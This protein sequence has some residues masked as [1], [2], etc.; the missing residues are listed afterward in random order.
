MK[1]TLI[2]LATLAAVSGTAFAQSNVTLSGGYGLVVGTSKTG[3]TST[4][5]QIARQT[6]NLNFAGT[7]DLGGG[8]KAGFQLQT[9]IGAHA[10]TSLNT[11]GAAAAATTLGDRGANVT[12][13]GAFGTA[14]VGR[15][16]SAVLGLWGAIGDVSQSPVLSGLSAGNSASTSDAKGGDANS[17]VIYGDAYSNYI[18]YS[19]P[20]FNGFSASVALAGVD[21]TTAS[22]KDTTS[23]TL[24]YA[25]GPLAAAVNL[26]D[27]KQTSGQAAVYDIDPAV[28]KA[29][30]PAVGAYKMTTVLASYD[31]GVVKVGLTS[32]QIKLAS[33]VN[34][35]NAMALTAAAPIGAGIVSL[36]YGKRSASASSAVAFG[37]DVKQTHVGY[38]YNLSKRT[39]LNLISNKINRAGTAADVTETSLVV[40]HTF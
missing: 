3:T 36:G 12:L 39:N 24:Q 37:D 25:N 35:G 6:G 26:T 17:R 16:A 19:S 32:Q 11:T 13:S 10:A 15:G 14:F 21:G 18:A 38:R 29:Y 1:K 33:G 23:F 2:A 40:G 34:P 22:T 9:S 7:E 8:L 28:A 27:S 31:L 5:T 30:I 4:G 20:A